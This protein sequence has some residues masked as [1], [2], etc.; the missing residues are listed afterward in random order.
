[1]WGPC[2]SKRLRDAAVCLQG[3]S[4][5][6]SGQPVI[7][8]QKLG[9]TTWEGMGVLSAWGHPLHGGPVLREDR[10]GRWAHSDP[11]GT[12]HFKGS[13]AAPLSGASQRHRFSELSPQGSPAQQGSP[14]SPHRAGTQADG[15]TDREKRPP[16]SSRWW[17]QTHRS[18]PWGGKQG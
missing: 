9:L 7:K 3:P 5:P 15:Q 16:E 17:T 14:P 4:P 1:M 2:R 8:W 13:S 12:W 11:G 18:R 6:E 10:A